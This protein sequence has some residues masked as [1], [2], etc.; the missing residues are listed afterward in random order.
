MTKKEQI[1][2]I[3]Q[4]LDLIFSSPCEKYLRREGATIDVGDGVTLR[5][6]PNGTGT[7]TLPG[8]IKKIIIDLNFGKNKRQT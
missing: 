6:N 4:H 2:E 5:L 7:Y 8:E 1:E 3:R